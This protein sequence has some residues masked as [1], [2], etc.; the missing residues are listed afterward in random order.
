ME[1]EVYSNPRVAS[2]ANTKFVAYKVDAESPEHRNL[3]AQ[4][5]VTQYPTIAFFDANGN[6]QEI[7]TGSR[8]VN[9]F[10]QELKRYA[11][12]MANA[13]LTGFR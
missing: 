12:K 11:P 4:V 6:L 9:G 10:L 1:A 3:V 8:T 5:G 2:E 13:S 7:I